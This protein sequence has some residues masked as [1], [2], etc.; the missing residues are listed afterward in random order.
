VR[1]I[2]EQFTVQAPHCVLLFRVST[3]LPVQQTCHAVPPQTVPLVTVR[4]HP[5]DSV[6][7][8]LP[9]APPAQIR[10]V[11]VRLCVP[12]VSQAPANPPQP[13]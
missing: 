13:P 11:T 10:M 4:E 6:L 8:G 5:R 9:Q 7:V 2:A 3:Q 12:V 1:P